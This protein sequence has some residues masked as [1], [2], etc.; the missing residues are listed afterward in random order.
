M[1]Y[2]N[3]FSTKYIGIFL[4][5]FTGCVAVA[6]TDFKGKAGSSVFFSIEETS[7]KDEIRWLKKEQLIAKWNSNKVTSYGIYKNR[8]HIFE[9]GTLQL[10]KA[11]EGD[12]GNYTVEIYWN[13]GVS[14]PNITWQCL[15]PVKFECKVNEKNY[16]KFS[17]K[18]NDNR[19]EK[20][21]E[22][23]KTTSETFGEVTCKVKNAVSEEDTTIKFDCRGLQLDLY[24]I[25]S[26]AGGGLL[27]LISIILLIYCCRRHRQKKRDQSEEAELQVQ[28]PEESAPVPQRRTV[29]VGEPPRQ[30]KR[31]P[32]PHPRSHKS[33]PRQPAP[34][35]ERKKSPKQVYTEDF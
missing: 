16:E 9:N 29:S 15:T 32:Q 2:R 3:N 24:M 5:T 17:W 31:P 33:A 27:L 1:A 8:C 35:R 11:Q 12:G 34:R 30:P 25:A 13:E 26:I 19:W 18:I 7:K 23:S 10:D 4:L 28:S 6:A 21:D 20:T 22:N 14:K